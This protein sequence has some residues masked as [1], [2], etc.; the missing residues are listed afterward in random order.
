MQVQS[1]C[2][3]D[4]LEQEITTHYSILAWKILWT[5]DP[6]GVQSG[7]LKG[8]DMTEHTHTNI[9][10]LNKL[11]IYAAVSPPLSPNT[12]TQMHTLN[13]KTEPWVV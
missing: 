1:L 5:E 11:Q 12:H 7:G 4:L 9:Y 2:W 6:G 13:E 10:L 8:L 3:E